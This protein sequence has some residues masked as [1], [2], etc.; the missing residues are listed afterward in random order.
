MTDYV[1]IVGEYEITSG[2]EV[3]VFCMQPFGAQIELKALW[4]SDYSVE[5]N[6]TID[7]VKRVQS[8]SVKLT[9]NGEETKKFTL[10][11][12]SN[13]LKFETQYTY[14]DGTLTP[15]LEESVTVTMTSEF[16]EL[17]GKDAG[18][19]YVM[20]C[21]EY[22]TL[23]AEDVF[24]GLLNEETASDPASYLVDFLKTADEWY[25]S[26]QETENYSLK[27]RLNYTLKYN[28]E[29]YQTGGESFGL[30]LIGANALA[31]GIEMDEGLIF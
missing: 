14:T 10:E 4:H 11:T 1:K 2:D 5:G 19:G 12:E 28:D 3:I 24:A 18:T 9:A 21:N 27:A 31:T 26:N 7:Y 22:L 23:P 17:Y 20:N 6:C 13:V 16:Q 15:T 8:V 25:A 29:T 30:F